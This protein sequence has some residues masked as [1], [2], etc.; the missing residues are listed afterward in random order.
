MTDMEMYLLQ[1]LAKKYSIEKQ[2]T[3]TQPTT[4]PTPPTTPP[5]YPTTPPT[6][7]P[8]PPTQPTT[9]PTPPTYPG[10]HITSLE[11]TLRDI[12]NT[13]YAMNIR[14]TTMADQDTMSID[15]VTASI[16]NPPLPDIGRESNGGKING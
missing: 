8:T 3:P 12:Q 1:E 2:Q 6:Y 5:T 11:Q 9:P 14:G 15:S 7:P 16:I 13:L 4:P 10:H